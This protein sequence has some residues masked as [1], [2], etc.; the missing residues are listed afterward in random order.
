MPEIDDGGRKMIEVVAIVLII[1]LVVAGMGV[2][3]AIISSESD[4]DDC[5]Y[6]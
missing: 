3:A 1:L 6:E 4:A 5:T 2:M